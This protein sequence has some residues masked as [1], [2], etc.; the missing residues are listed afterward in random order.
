MRIRFRLYIAIQPCRRPGRCARR[1]GSGALRSKTPMLSRPRKPP[2]NTLRPCGVLAVDPPGEVEHA[3]CGTPARGT[4]GRPG[5]RRLLAVDLEHPPRGPGVDRRVDVAE[6]PLVGREL[7]VGV[8]VPLAR[9][10]HELLLGEL[11]ID[12]RQRDAVERQVPGRVPG[13][14]PLVRHRDDVGVVEVRPLAIA[15]A[16]C[17]RC[18]RRR[19]AGVAVEPL[20]DVEVDRTACST[21][22]RRRPG[23]APARSSAPAM[24]RCRS[25]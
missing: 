12:Q 22:S 2:W 13:I 10:Q 20:R 8:H 17:V 19:L 6:G 18:R 1:S 25:P 3:A 4:R 14:L 9:Q 11:G 21:A 7:P 5:R 23:A 24:S 16:T 15:A